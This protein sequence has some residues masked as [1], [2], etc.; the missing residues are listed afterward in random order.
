ML[1]LS[2]FKNALVTTNLL[3]RIAESYYHLQFQ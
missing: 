1:Y 3:Y 2:I